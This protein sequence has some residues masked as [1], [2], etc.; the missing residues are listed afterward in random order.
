MLQTVTGRTISRRWGP[1]AVGMLLAL[2]PTA[3]PAA[4]E[5]SFRGPLPGPG[6]PSDSHPWYE[7]RKQLKDN[8]ELVEEESPDGGLTVRRELFSDQRQQMSLDLQAALAAKERCSKEGDEEAR[9]ILE[10]MK[11]SRAA[12][13]PV[14]ELAERWYAAIGQPGFFENFPGPE[15][16][17][18]G[19][20]YLKDET[21]RI[22]G[23]Y[24]EVARE[25]DEM[26]AA[27]EEYDPCGSTE[28]ALPE[29]DVEPGAPP[30]VGPKDEDQLKIAS[31]SGRPLPRDEVVL[32]DL[33]D[34][35]G[36]AAEG[37][38]DDDTQEETDTV[39]AGRTYVVKAT[40]HEEK[41]VSGEDL[42]E[43]D[44]QLEPKQRPLA[45]WVPIYIPREGD[46]PLTE[47]RLRSLEGPTNREVLDK[48]RE[49]L[50][51]KLG[52]DLDDY[53]VEIEPAETLL[54]PVGVWVYRVLLTAKRPPCPDALP[55]E[56]KTA[57]PQIAG[58]PPPAG[59]DDPSIDPLIPAVP[60]GGTI[61]GT[62]T[63]EDKRPAATA[64]NDPYLRTAGTWGQDYP[65]QWG[66]RRI[67]FGP[68][69]S[70]WPAAA[71]PVVVA[72][73]DT[74]VDRSHPELRDAIR[75]NEGEI[76]G[77]GLD[78]DGNGYV[79]DVH[80][81]NFADDS[82]DTRDIN[83]H[84]TV[85]A[86]IIAAATGNG[87]GI[88]GVNPWARILPVRIAVW[89]GQ[90]NNLRLAEAIRYAVDNGARVINISYGGLG[91]TWSEYLAV[92]YARSR[93]VIVVAAAGNDGAEAAGESPAGL[94]GVIT[95]AATRPDD[96]RLGFSNWGPG[97]D[98]AAPGLDVLS[99]RARHTDLL[100]FKRDDYRAGA[101]I[102]GDDRRYYRLTGTSFSAPF[103]AGV[104][105]LIW[106]LRPDL[107]DMQ[108]MRM[109][110][111]SARDIGTPGW[112]QYTGYGLLDAGA[113]LAADPDFYLLARLS[114]VA[115]RQTDQG[116]VVE[117]SGRARADRFGRAWLE[118]GRGDSPETWR[119]VSEDLEQP[120]DGGVV[121]AI[122]ADRLRGSK[123][124]TLRLVVEH[125]G[126][127][128]REA[129]FALTLR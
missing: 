82:S 59:D 122:P 118:L 32:V 95:V 18:S 128:R 19:S 5:E 101:V 29:P 103:V 129:R 10:R 91:R 9:R 27:A 14:F 85:T 124:W 41:I 88:A 72:V 123:T 34:F 78:D 106:S 39:L 46:G 57:D 8:F 7:V 2:W 3:R 23:L 64:A 44:V 50:E 99:L 84:G 115:V 110:L 68:G 75:V 22:V 121:A 87:A 43:G 48:A 70:L 111:H 33:P 58:D 114:G 52:K 112:D 15:D 102:V 92:A 89:S 56:E 36:E 51:E 119:R 67:G 120:V 28:D 4:A 63:R 55:E 73:I 79:D 98:I 53:N 40:C 12:L 108:V 6:S 61:E 80:G 107:T 69:A 31:T 125:A 117:V 126:G 81:W 47:E 65:D 105:S 13:D 90:S 74:G 96:Q 42:L 1:L 30:E 71:E 38:P 97:V 113:A 62:V 25:L 16:P 21:E 116:Q 24:R 76:P 86:G 109:V 11:A 37:G 49:V 104:A 20:G 60:A 83:G 77:N 17:Y 35:P 54:D 127:A 26:I 45:L 94:P 93:G 100:R 66:L